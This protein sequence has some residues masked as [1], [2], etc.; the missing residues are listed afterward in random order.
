M[1]IPKALQLALATVSMVAGTLIPVHAQTN[2]L[3]ETKRFVRGSS[4]QPKYQSF[5]IPLDSQKGVELASTGDNA[6]KFTDSP[7]FTRV[8]K[9]ALV[10]PLYSSPLREAT[11]YHM[12]ETATPAPYDPAYKIENPLVAMGSGAGGSPLYVGQKYSVGLYGGVR[13]EGYTVGSVTAGNAGLHSSVD[14]YVFVYQKNGFANGATNVAWVNMAGLQIPRRG[15][16]QWDA[17]RTTGYAVEN[18]TLAAY[19]FSFTLRLVESPGDGSGADTWG[20]KDGFYSPM[21]LTV[22]AT[23]P[24]Y[25]FIVGTVGG[26]PITANG[27]TV[28][29]PTTAILTTDGQVIPAVNPLCAMDFEPRPAWRS[30]FIHAPHFDGEPIPSEYQG[31]S[32]TELQAV[33]TTVT[34]QLGAVVAAHTA[35][36]NS[37]ELRRHPILDK[38]VADMGND[39]VALTNYVLN[40]IQLTDAI[41]YND[42]GDI[43]EASI[44]AGGVNRGALATFLEGQ[45]SPVEQSALLVYLLR[46]A[47][48]PAV[49]VF[50]APDELKMLNT[51]MSKLLR[52]Q[53]KGM[54]DEKGEPTVPAIIPVNYPWVALSIPDPVPG[55]SANRKWVHV[56]P[57]LKDTE[58]KEGGNVYDYMPAGYRSGFQWIRKYLFNDSAILSLNSESDTV[59]TLFPAFVKKQLL[60]NHPGVAYDGLGIRARDRRNYYSAWKDFPQP[61]SVTE[62]NGTMTVRNDLSGLANIFDTVAVTVWSDRNNDGAWTSGEPR[63]QTGALNASDLHNRRFVLNFQRTSGD[64]HN[65]LLTM[66]PYRPGTT[67]TGTYGTSN[68]LLKQQASV[69]VG[70]TDYNIKIRLVHKRQ[71]SLPANF[72]PGYRWDNPF[73]YTGTR[74]IDQVLGI[75]K[76]DLAAI[77]IN[78]GRVSQ[79]MV[80]VH[81]Q[82]FWA[83]EKRL[84]DNPGAAGDADVYLGTTAYIMGMSYYEK[85]ARSHADLSDLHKTNIAS[86]FAHGLAKLGARRNANGTLI[87]SGEIDLVYPVVDMSFNWLGYAGNAT[88]RPDKGGA[89]VGSMDNFIVLAIGDISAQE[90]AAIN[91]YFK[92]FDSVST[93]RLLHRAQQNGQ[94]L[95]ELT[96][97]NY[98]AK[99]NVNYTFNGTT[100]MLKDWCGTA[101]WT[102]I[103]QGFQTN[104]VWQDY[105]L[106]LITPGPVAGASGSYKGIGAFVI[107]PEGGAAYITSNLNGGYGAPVF[108]STFSSS[109]FSNIS[110]SIGSSYSPSLNFANTFTPS[111]PSFFQP[112]STSWNATSNYNSILGGSSYVSSYQSSSWNQFSLDTGYSFTGGSSIVS[113]SLYSKITD[114]G[115]AGS[116]SYYGNIHSSVPQGISDPVNAVTGEFY[117]DAVDIRL[118]GPMP[119]EIRRNYSSLNRADNDFGYGWKL[120]Y[121]PYLVVGENEDV[122]QAA[123]MD[124]SVI[125]YRKQSADLWKPVT[126]DNPH[127]I[128]V[129]GKSMGSTGNFFNAQ[130]A[131]STSGG[132]TYYDL[133]G[134]DGSLR[135]FK[136]RSFPVNSNGLT[137]NYYNGTALADSQLRSTRIDKTIN[138]S[139]GTA[140][141]TGVNVPADLFSIRWTGAI[142]APATG[143]YT[144]TTTASDGV[145]LWIGGQQIIN[146]WVN[147]GVTAK[148]G[149]V[150]LTA[151]QYYEIKL[152]YYDNT[153][154]ASVKLEWAYPGQAKQVVPASAL[155]PDLMTPA[156]TGYGQLSRVQA[157]NGNFLG[158]YYDTFGHINEVYTG[159]G[160]RLSY[161]YDQYGDLIQVRLPD[162]SV[163]D[164]DY[165]HDTE[166]VNSK[167]ETYSKHLIIRETKPAGRVLEN[168]YDSQG[169]VTVQRASVGEDLKPV[170]NAT[171]AYTHTVNSDDT[172]TGHTL[173]TDA[174][175]RV[176]RYDYVNSQLTKVTDPLSQEIVQEWYAPTDTSTGAYPR[177]L[178]KRVDKR[179]L[180][181][182]F[183]Y[184]AKGNLTE[185]RTTGEL[186]GDTTPDVAITSYAYNARNLITDTTDP[187]G[188]RTVVLYEDANQ[189]WLPTTVEK[190][191]TSGLV[192][193]LK[194]TYFNVGSAIPRAYGL[195]QSETRAFGTSD[196]ATITFTYNDNGFVTSQTQATGTADPAVVTTLRHNLRGEL[197]EHVDSLGRKITYAYDDMGRRIAEERR[198]EAGVLK[199]WNYTYYNANGEVEWV[200]GPRSGPEDYA[201]RFYDGAGRLIE[202][203]QQRSVVKPAFDGVYAPLGDDRYASVFHR[204]DKFGNR[205]ETR[206]ARRNSTVMDYDDIGRLTQRRSYQGTATGTLLATESWTYEPGDEIATHTDALGGVTT[207]LYTQSGLPR[208]KTESDGSV[209]EWRYYLDGR[210]QREP[211]THATY[212]EITYDDHARTITRVLKTTAG[213]TL[214]TT[215]ETYDRRGNLLSSTDEEGLTVT[216]TYDALDRVKTKTGPGATASSAQQVFTTL[217]DASGKVTTVSDAL[218]NKTITTKD[219]LGRTVSEEVRDPANAVV[220]QTT[221]AYPADHHSVTVTEGTGPGALVTTTYTDTTGNPVLVI[222]GDGSRTVSTYD[223]GGL[224]VSARDELGHVTAYAHD[225]LGRLATQ[226]LPDGAATTLGYDA[227]GN[228][229]SRVMPG[230]LT[231][232]GT[233]DTAGRLTTEALNNGST[234]SRQFGYTYYT[235]GAA[236]GKLHTVTDPRGIVHTTAYDAFLRPA[237]VAASGPGTADLTRTYAYDK[238]GLL[239]EQEQTYANPANGPPVSVTRSYDGYGQLITENVQVG[240]LPH[241]SVTHTWDA[242]GRRTSLDEADAGLAG[243]LFAYNYRADGRLTQVTANGQ[244]YGFGYAD[245]GLLTSRGNP[246]RSLAINT[247]DAAG[248]ITQQ[249]ITVGAQTSVEATTWRAN[250]TLATYATTRNGVGA[251]NESRA[252]TYNSR[253]QLL[254]EGYSPA[255]GV[256]ATLTYTF[257]NGTAGVGV[258][259]SA[260]VG[261]GAP[262][263]WEW[264]VV[265]QS[266]LARV[267]QDTT[268]GAL[269]TI[270]ASGYALG[271]ERVNVALNGVPVVGVSHPGWADPAGQWAASLKVGV[272]THVLD[273][274]APHP[275]GQFTAGA[276]STFTVQSAAETITNSYD[277]AGNLTYRLWSDGRTQS[278]TW[279]SAGRLIKVVQR[280]N[281]GKGFDWT[282]VYDGT[283]RRLKTREQPVALN[284]PVAAAYTIGS[285]YDPLVENLEIGV[286]A[287]GVKTWKVH[288][289]DLDG[290]YGGL[291]GIGGLEALI[292]EGGE[293]LA[294]IDDIWGNS[295][296][297]VRNGAIEWNRTRV[298][299]YGPLPGSEVTLLTHT[300]SLAETL[301]WKGKRLDPTG[302]YYLGARYYDPS[303]GRFISAD[304][305]GHA[306]SMSLYD[307]ANGD[308]VN[309]LDPDGRLSVGAW[310]YSSPSYSSGSSMLADFGM[311]LAEGAIGGLIG[312]IIIGAVAAISAP[313]AIVLGVAAAA[314]GLYTWHQNDY[315][316][317]ARGVGQFIGSLATGGIGAR[318]GGSMVSG[319]SSSWSAS[320]VSIRP[321]VSS[322][323]PTISSATVDSSAAIRARV[324]ANIAETRSATQNINRGLI[325]MDLRALTTVSARQVDSLGMRA[326]TPKQA[327]A[328]Q[329]NPNLQPAFRGNRIDV[330]TRAYVRQDPFLRSLQSNYTRGPDFRQTRTNLWWDMTTPA[331]WP[332][333]VQK[334]GNGGTLLSTN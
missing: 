31:K 107:Y 184:D 290:E 264:S 204:Y 329:R 159:D 32:L 300:T 22:E 205:I 59:G 54:V 309:Q 84:R 126:A 221:Y 40:E 110:L 49:Y 64:N 203:T 299:G 306:A 288:G 119:L 236:K 115:Y 61:W 162:A 182:E 332:A 250:T 271:A 89:R 43:T 103:V 146:N 246:W 122:I 266:V 239:T 136:L 112:I 96:K 178:K 317:S 331:Q 262:A 58:I 133:T 283:G 179:G 57:W 210:V 38:F 197:I 327:A 21:V 74:E 52:M 216:A 232:S 252:Y 292:T 24:D 168:D 1:T 166:V 5:V 158:F 12:L 278:L 142:L 27:S 123:E 17:F 194:K 87:N 227:E 36:D 243:S 128:N 85:V 117:V 207:T 293:T 195:L 93:V 26:F 301:S 70:S 116:S 231:W 71:R 2:E 95:V 226:T 260:E 77:C 280:D 244:A 219:I 201:W 334:Y 316:I 234:V 189:A 188:N 151:G 181:T 48:Y 240:G 29:L 102:T 161:R 18:S 113:S 211:V 37:V 303:A 171:F 98:V 230:G 323:S 313:A 141:P 274:K 109:N 79:R 193:Q 165:K 183:K 167:T 160:R 297:L 267:T 187:V 287:A 25:S 55:N 56:F 196:A 88:A 235:S 253:G 229:T 170:T 199:G 192:S 320:A 169:R 148:T 152:E 213:A 131:R 147:Q 145:R 289:P 149:Q 190:R 328:I 66:A 134:P 215:T 23:N 220:R 68:I 176:G 307:Y 333:H 28:W 304:P 86:T 53:F 321:S 277:E 97:E 30:T 223:A 259:T 132:N 65:M 228:L 143:T 16:P 257:D 185:A 135:R 275:S 180:V 217:Y 157:S 92:Q 156:R 279:D 108:N 45:G 33:S 186:T 144:F 319:V 270:P 105:Q 83:E 173:V 20:V 198:D 19:G 50:P 8:D 312:G 310:N 322:P 13:S 150:A 73:G 200:D 75:S 272:G 330:R 11:V 268:N 249:T 276:Q 326:F 81:A 44:N 256:S 291:H 9:N 114:I 99:G 62:V 175:S 91:T 120:G 245:T 78:L 164:Y 214:A 76:G 265:S 302:F 296:G 72:A 295:V 67:G 127:L 294:V 46:Q 254:T 314:Y 15:T 206:D 325:T 174:Y 80:D 318:L 137:G 41:G 94:S 298:S 284:V 233:Y 241:S 258:R 251:W 82:E 248:R 104:Q 155:F 269:R 224:L 124:G 14:F 311:G 191:S 129:N 163:I 285:I 273:V 7:W 130:L 263:Q 212:R 101:T 315:A 69:A 106:V 177:S 225:A 308:P 111:S 255:P 4:T 172:I 305:E 3:A 242:A 10:K 286:I 63:I 281:A 218:G 35:L 125:A 100:K 222:K 47:G 118:E 138:F 42:N 139:F 39:P 153:S 34:K 261:A 282:A 90:H 154:T 121:F 237:S 208:H 238:R 60:L 6:G 140:A 324:L 209:L 247:R 202:E 51:R